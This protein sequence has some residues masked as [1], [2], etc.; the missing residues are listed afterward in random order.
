ATNR[1]GEDIEQSL[2]NYALDKAYLELSSNQ[3]KDK[4]IDE[5]VVEVEK[6]GDEF[7]AELNSFGFN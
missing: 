6:M 2:S 1:F 3:H 5:I 7:K 4:V